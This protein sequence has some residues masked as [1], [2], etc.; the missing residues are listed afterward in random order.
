MTLK[1]TTKSIVFLLAIVTYCT[2]CSKDENGIVNNADIAASADEYVRSGTLLT[3]AESQLDGDITFKFISV[4]VNDALILRETSG[5]LEVANPFAFDYETNTMITGEIEASNGTESEVLSLQIDVNDIDDLWYFL[6]TPESKAAYKAA[7]PGEWIQIQKDEYNTLRSTITEVSLVG[8]N[9]NLYDDG[10]EAAESTLFIYEDYTVVN[11]IDRIPE[12]NF[13]FAFKYYTERD[14]IS[15]SKVKVSSTELTEGFEDLG[16]LLPSHN[17]GENFFVLKGNEKK[18]ENGALAMYTQEGLVY[19][20]DG[21]GVRHFFAS[22]DT[23]D[24]GR[25]FNVAELTCLYQGLSTPIKQ[26]D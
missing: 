13:V 8:T 19:L 9:A 12:D 18:T 15:E 17:G 23:N 24:I 25:N 2:S 4:S 21:S 20:R 26:W 6:K 11:D 16:N 3:T 22:G 1:A 7:S 14:N 5:N 10:L